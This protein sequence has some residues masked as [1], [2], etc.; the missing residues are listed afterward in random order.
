MVRSLRYSAL[1]IP[2]FALGTPSAS[3]DNDFIVYSPYVVQGQNEIETK[4]FE[5]QDARGDLNGASGYDISVSHA[6]TQWWKP[7][8]YIGQFNREPGASTQLSGYEIENTFQLTGQG[9]YWADIGFIASYAHAKLAGTTSS[10]EFGPLLEKRLGRMDHRLNLIWEKQVGSGE[11]AQYAFRSAYSFSYRVV[12][13]FAPGFEAY[14]R[15]ND[16]ANQIGPVVYGEFHF[17]A[18]SELE[19][20]LG[21]VYGINA[22]APDRTLLARLEYEFF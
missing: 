6:V 10:L 18:K 16:N 3:A 5:S 21:I 7:E 13:E 20:S 22:S 15:P 2:L 1:L 12:A 17:G 14:Y 9:E 4:G 11:S 19:Y 8:L